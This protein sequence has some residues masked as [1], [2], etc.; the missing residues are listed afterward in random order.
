MN[1]STVDVAVYL[2]TPET[3]ETVGPC[4]PAACVSPAGQRNRVAPAVAVERELCV[5]GCG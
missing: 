4:K 5:L 3:C 1:P 2:W